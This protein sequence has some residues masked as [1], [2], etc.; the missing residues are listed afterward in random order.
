M[1][2]CIQTIEK[3]LFLQSILPNTHP[4]HI[5]SFEKNG[6]AFRLKLCLENMDSRNDL[7]TWVKS[8]AELSN[9][10]YWKCNNK[11]YGRE[12][13]LYSVSQKELVIGSAI[14][15]RRI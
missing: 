9:C 10:V 2:S 4:Y 3:W 7:Q 14:N 1:T 8:F 15:I 13:S 12:G 11:Q 5:I 6:S